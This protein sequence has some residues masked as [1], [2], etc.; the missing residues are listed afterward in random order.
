[1]MPTVINRHH[2]KRGLPVGTIYVGR[3]T[4][5]G[6][7]YTLAEHG[8]AALDL[9][10][11]WLREKIVKGDRAIIAALDSIGPD[12]MLACSCA[13]RPCHASIIARIWE[14]RAGKGDL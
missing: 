11:T 13:P 8:P 12:S 3:G 5:L 1:M 10:E 4:P 2:Y 7:P 9:Y 14:D 6:N